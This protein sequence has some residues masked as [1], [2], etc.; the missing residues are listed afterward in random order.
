[1]RQARALMSENLGNIVHVTVIDKRR[2]IRALGCKNVVIP[3]FQQIKELL[4]MQQV[5]AP[6]FASIIEQLTYLLT[7]SLCPLYDI[8]CSLYVSSDLYEP[9]SSFSSVPQLVYRN[10]HSQQQ[11][12]LWRKSLSS[13]TSRP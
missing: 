4:F 3:P 10:Q 12:Q 2:D 6:P 5:S 13:R 1:M 8:S 7:I 11:L 9:H